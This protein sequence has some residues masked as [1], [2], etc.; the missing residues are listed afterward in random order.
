MSDLLKE[1]IRTVLIEK[2]GEGGAEYEQIV[3]NAIKA[4]GAS[5]RMKHT[6]GF[7]PNLPDA[8]ITINGEVYNVEVKM[9]GN[10]QMGGGSIGMKDGKFF[11]AGKDIE[12]MEPIAE[13]LNSSPDSSK[14]ISAIEKFCSFLNKKGK[15]VG[16]PVYGFP[17]SGFSTQ[18]WKDAV[19]AGLLIPINTKLESSIDFIAEHYASKGTSYIQIGGQGL[20]YLLDNPANIPVPRLNGSVV[21][22]V[23]AARAGSGG[24]PTASAGIRV[25]PRLKIEAN[26]PYSLD[27]PQSIKELLASTSKKAKKK[28]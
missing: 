22:E 2:S 3:F 26:S 12:A 17:M 28:R 11:A 27:D 23:R 13:S 9:D 24:R 7:D 18:A 4:A 19:D 1:Y 8:D 10:A 6:A 5:G 15:G 16:K 14:L 21:L 20:F 25:Q